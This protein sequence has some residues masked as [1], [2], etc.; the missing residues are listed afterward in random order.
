MKI[1]SLQQSYLIIVDPCWQEKKN[2]SFFY[3]LTELSKQKHRR[4]G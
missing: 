4:F 1:N 3:H 2:L